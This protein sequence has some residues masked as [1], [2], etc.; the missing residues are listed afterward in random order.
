MIRSPLLIR[1]DPDTLSRYLSVLDRLKLSDPPRRQTLVLSDAEDRRKNRTTD[2]Y[3]AFESLRFE[4]QDARYDLRRAAA[5]YPKT[6]CFGKD[7]R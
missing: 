5:V 4:S 2:E 6:A 7:D 3:G 1:E